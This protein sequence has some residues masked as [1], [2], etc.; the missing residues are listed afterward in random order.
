MADRYH[1]R[2]E[3]Y[4]LNGYPIGV[5]FGDEFTWLGAIAAVG[6]TPTPEGENVLVV[7]GNNIE[8]TFE[9]VTGSGYTTAVVET[10]ASRVSPEG[11]LLPDHALLPGTRATSFAYIGLSTNAIYEGLIQVDVLEEGSRLFYASGVG[12][13]FRDFTVVGSIE[14]ARG[15]IPRFN[16]LPTGGKRLETGP[17]EVVL[18]EDNR[19]LPEVTAYKFWR[20]DLAMTV[21][22]DMPGGDPC[23]WEFIKWLRRYPESARTYYDAGQ[24]ANAPC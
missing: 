4:G 5:P 9:S 24:Y 12:D 3:R 23:P 20:L 16:E 7:P 21:P 8:V 6:Y 18:V 15:T 14:D 10:T 19:A 22:G 11:N 2:I 17:T 1:D 13:T